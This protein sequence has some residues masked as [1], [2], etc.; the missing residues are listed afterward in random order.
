MAR[1]EKAARRLVVDGATYMWS[2][3]HTHH[4]LGGGRYEDC[5]ETLVIR[6][7]KAR[8]RLRISFGTGPGKLVPDGYMPSGAVGTTGG[9]LLNLHEPGTVR[10]LLDEA[11]S[12]G[13]RPDDPPV[14]ELDGWN[15]FDAVAARRRPSGSN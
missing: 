5:C 14:E 11:L 13:W 6:L 1:K 8:G 9:G 2:I 15:L 12:Q 10:A 7:F 3:G 4:V